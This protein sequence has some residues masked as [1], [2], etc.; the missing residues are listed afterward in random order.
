M[1]MLVGAGIL[2]SPVTSCLCLLEQ[3]FYERDRMASMEEILMPLALMPA[4]LY[5]ILISVP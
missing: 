1:L 5:L 4:L 3:L 2:L